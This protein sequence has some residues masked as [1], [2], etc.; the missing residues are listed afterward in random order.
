MPLTATKQR[1]PITDQIALSTSGPA[2]MVVP[3]VAG[4]RVVVMSMLLGAD[5]AG[6]IEVYEG[7][8]GS[9][10]G[11]LKIG[12]IP[13]SDVLPSLIAVG[14]PDC[15]VRTS[16]GKGIAIAVTGG[17]VVTGSISYYYEGTP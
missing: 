12:S 13:V 10:G 15:L 7:D 3:E 17:A 14:P 5:V 8:T 4:M 1:L 6:N 16:Q 11:T 2:A 9:P